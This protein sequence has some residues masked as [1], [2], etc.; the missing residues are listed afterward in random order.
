MTELLESGVDKLEPGCLNSALIV[1]VRNNNQHHVG[2]LIL[3][4]ATNITDALEHAMRRKSHL[5]SAMLL[6]VH[7]AMEGDRS[8]IQQVFGDLA[9]GGESCKECSKT[10]YKIPYSISQSFIA[11]ILNDSLPEIRGALERGD[12]S[13]AP[14]IEIARKKYSSRK[15]PREIA[16]R[17]AHVQEELLMRTNVNKAKKSVHWHKLHLRSLEITWL[18]RIQWVKTLLLD[19]NYLGFLPET[20]EVYLEQVCE[21]LFQCF[22]CAENVFTNIKAFTFTVFASC[23]L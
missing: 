3:K 7:A 18:E 17:C 12:I 20:V 4:G 22:L 8:L 11:S 23:R 16:H 2:Q 6:L 1:A 19:Q 10:N 21:F 14:P 9:V 5:A 13:T 15:T